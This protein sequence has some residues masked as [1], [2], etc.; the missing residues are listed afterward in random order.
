MPRFGKNVRVGGTNG[1]RSRLTRELLDNFKGGLIRHTRHRRSKNFDRSQLLNASTFQLLQT[2]RPNFFSSSAFEIW[3]MVGRPCG[4]Q[5][6]RSHSSKSW[7]SFST[8]R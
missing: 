5:Y 6:G 8:S 7:I 4:Q 3:I 2:L 1:G